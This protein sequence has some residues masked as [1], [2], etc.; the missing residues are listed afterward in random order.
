MSGFFQSLVL[1]ATRQAAGFDV[2]Y[3]LELRPSLAFDCVERFG[4]FREKGSK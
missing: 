3:L 4:V 1:V 2:W